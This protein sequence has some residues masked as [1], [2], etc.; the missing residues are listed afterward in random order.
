M[1]QTII[2]DNND[3]P[4]Q[5][6]STKKSAFRRLAITT[7][8]L[9]FDCNLISDKFNKVIIIIIIIQLAPLTI[10]VIYGEK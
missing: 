1:L 7:K 9:S 3:T 4:F 8:Q 6:V 5:N 10:V 2:T